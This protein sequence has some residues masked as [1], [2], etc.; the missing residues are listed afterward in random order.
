MA[1]LR[2]DTVYQRTQAGQREAVAK[3]LDLSPNARRLLLIVNG[4]T[5]LRVLLDLLRL[6]DESV[7][8]TILHLVELGL[9]AQREPL[10][11]GRLQTTRS[12]KGAP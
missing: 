6:E 9:I 7:I 5:P 3:R 11:R 8:P 2:D 1:L 4:E 10:A 12:S